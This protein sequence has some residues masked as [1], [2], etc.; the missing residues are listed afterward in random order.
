MFKSLPKKKRAHLI[1]Y[2]QRSRFSLY[3]PGSNQVAAL[4]FPPTILN[5]LT[6]VDTEQFRKA[7]T[8]LLAQ[9]NL[10]EGPVLIVLATDVCFIQE[11]PSE[12]KK[13]E[14]TPQDIV[15]ELRSSMPFANVFARLLQLGKRQLAIGLNR[16]FYEPL[17]AA[18]HE[19]GFEVTTLI[20]EVVLTTPLTTTGLTPELALGLSAAVD[21]LE[22]FDLLE[23]SEKPK[24]ITTSAQTPEDKKRTLLLVG[25][26][27]F[28]TLLLVGVWWW[29]NRSQPN[30][31]TVVPV[32]PVTIEEPSGLVLEPVTAVPDPLVSTASAL[33]DESATPAAAIA[34][35]S[36]SES[37]SQ[38]TP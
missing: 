17:L 36:A 3:M 6:V 20:P 10:D 29:T 12:Q 34:S 19:E 31:P 4:D 23:S 13:G 30:K 35:E 28:L 18:F 15:K 33:L 22:A 21:K 1:G 11:V 24:M 8:K 9:Y 2:F 7:I 38:T 27:V 26:F 16:E 37:A 14:P 25:V 5:D 32:V